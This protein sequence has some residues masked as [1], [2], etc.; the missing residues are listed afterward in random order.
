MAE[1]DAEVPVP[2]QES[3]SGLTRREFLKNSAKAA[4]LTT[5]AV[6][7]GS[8]ATGKLVEG[9]G[10]EDQTFE[11][12]GVKGTYEV[13]SPE[14]KESVDQT[15]AV[16]Y[17]PGWPWSANEE[18]TK[19]FPRRLAKNF[20][21]RCFNI[22]TKTPRENPEY[23]AKQAQA[24]LE[25]LKRNGINEA[26]IVGHSAGAI[27]GAYLEAAAQNDPDF[28]VKGVVIANTRGL[29]KIGIR[30]LLQRF[31][32]DAFEIGKEYRKKLIK[33]DI[34]DPSDQVIQSGFRASILRNIKEFGWGYIP[35]LL[36]QVKTLTQVDPIFGQIKAPVLVLVSE[37]DMVSE[38]RRYIPDEEV[39]KNL[40]VFP[41]EDSLAKQ[42]TARTGS[43]E[44]FFGKYLNALKKRINMSRF[45]KGREKYLQD[46]VFKSSAGVK[47]LRSER[48]GDHNAVPGPRAEQVSH[49]S[50]KTFDRMERSSKS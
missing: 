4:V 22:D 17:L 3:G 37:A 7:G 43:N 50:S 15:K 1:A 12:N 28:K 41:S 32:K 34:P 46:E 23:L 11:L 26:T 38:Y 49:I 27:K 42:A 19:E 6:I 39:A 36:D 18:P 33:I 16:I 20:G 9:V 40:P 14:G 29:D 5:A 10:K 44:G 13:F 48:Q 25:F 31:I 2:P 8:Y 45:T 24:T 21:V 47:V 30:D 35:L